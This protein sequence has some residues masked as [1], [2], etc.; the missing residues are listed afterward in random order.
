M[1]GYKNRVFVFSCPKCGFVQAGI[2]KRPRC[3]KCGKRV[4]ISKLERV[5]YSSWN[6]AD[7]MIRIVISRFRH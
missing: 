5:Y 6:H 7:P 4:D 2:G 3:K 1:D